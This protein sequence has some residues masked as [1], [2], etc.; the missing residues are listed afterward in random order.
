M[1][2]DHFTSEAVKTVSSGYQMWHYKVEF[3]CFKQL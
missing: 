2:L 3:K 1:P